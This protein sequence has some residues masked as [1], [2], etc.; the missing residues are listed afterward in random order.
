MLKYNFISSLLLV[1][2]LLIG[3]TSCEDF[4]ERY[5][6]ASMASEMAMADIEGIEATIY[7]LYSRFQYVYYNHREM[8]IVGEILSDQMDVAGVNTGRFLGHRINQEG[9]G[10]DLWTRLYNDINRANT[11]LYYIDGV[12]EASQERINWAKGQAYALRGYLYFDLLKIYARPYMYQEP[13]VQGQPLGVVY[14]TEP[15]LGVD[16][17]TFQARGTIEEGYQLVLDD[18][19]MARE[20]LNDDGFPIY[21]TKT[22]VKALLARLHLFMGNW[23]QAINYAEDVMDNAPIQLVE[24]ENYSDCFTEAPGAESLFEIKYIAT[25]RPSQI[26]SVAGNAYYSPDVGVYFG[27]IILR[28]D[29]LDLLEE[30]RAMGDVRPEMMFYEE[31]AGVEYGYQKKFASYRGETWWDDVRVIRIAEMYLIASE[32]HAELEEFDDAR[33]YL[34]ELRAH[35]GSPDVDVENNKE[36]FIELILDERRV[37]FYSEMSHRWFDLRRRGMDI[38]KGVPGVDAGELVEFSDY[39]VVERIPESDEIAV[40]ENLIQNPGY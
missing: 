13:L 28:Q 34:N 23:Q 24:A 26:G 20:L 2:G 40:N 15:F 38:P 21:L 4:V 11:V 16:E 8:N 30:Y 14:K 22:S 31:K 3:S 19:E 33:Y 39:R 7:G 6:R 27:D 25:D 1:A 18:L 5:P 35:R 9:T 17:N 36:A 32:A 29:L 12:E 37:E 10:F